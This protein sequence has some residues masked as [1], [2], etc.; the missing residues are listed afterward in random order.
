MCETILNTSSKGRL[1]GEQTEAVAIQEGTGGNRANG[2]CV[3]FTQTPERGVGT[4]LVGTQLRVK[5][6]GAMKYMEQ[7]LE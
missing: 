2:G 1:A 4:S 7:D 6:I 5:L 3:I